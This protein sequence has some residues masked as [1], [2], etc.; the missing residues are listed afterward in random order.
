MYCV[1]LVSQDQVIEIEIEGK[2]LALDTI[3]KF[4]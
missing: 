4:V 3:P 1:N 2:K